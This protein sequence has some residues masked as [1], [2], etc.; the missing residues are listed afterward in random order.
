M[1][2]RRKPPKKPKRVR[3]SEAE[4]AVI[5]TAA[6]EAET[7]PSTFVREASVDAARRQLTEQDAEL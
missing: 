6:N 2:P 3:F 5:V 7:W 4:W 1:P